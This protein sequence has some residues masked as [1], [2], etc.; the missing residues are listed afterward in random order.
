MWISGLPCKRHH[1][2]TSRPSVLSYVP[3]S[4]LPTTESFTDELPWEQW[5]AAKDLFGGGASGGPLSI[6]KVKWYSPFV[7]ISRAGL[8]ERGMSLQA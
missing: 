7:W 8:F 1:T 4:V 5:S 6:Q 3:G 2:C